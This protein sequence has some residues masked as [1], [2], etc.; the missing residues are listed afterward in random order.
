MQFTQNGMLTFLLQRSKIEKNSGMYLDEIKPVCADDVRTG[1]GTITR[2]E[3]R[4]AKNGIVEISIAAY[5][6][7]GELVLTNVTEAI[8]KCKAVE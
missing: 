1:K 8:V 5:N 4:N 2:T 6:Q 7:K 3:R